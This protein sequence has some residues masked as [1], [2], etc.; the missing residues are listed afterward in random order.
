MNN[1]AL[2]K[3]IKDTEDLARGLPI[4]RTAYERAVHQLAKNVA[5]LGTLLAPSSKK[6]CKACNI[7]VPAAWG[8]C[9]CGTDLE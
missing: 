7:Y 4:P 9:C 2:G 3:L 5:D 8:R 1:T 6:F